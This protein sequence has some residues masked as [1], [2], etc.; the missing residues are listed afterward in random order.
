MIRIHNKFTHTKP[1]AMMAIMVFLFQATLSFYQFS[2]PNSLEG[3]TSVVCTLSGA[4]TVYIPFE[5]EAP[6][7]NNCITCPAC[8]TFNHDDHWLPQVKQN[9]HLANFLFNLSA[10]VEDN[11]IT[12]TPIL[13]SYLSRAPPI[14]S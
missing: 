11:A 2:D 3:Y 10:S 14:Y 8:L 6:T 5:S 12:P 9:I 7:S 1:I 13:S 4:K